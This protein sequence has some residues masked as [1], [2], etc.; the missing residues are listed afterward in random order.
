MKKL[1]SLILFVTL[2]LNLVAQDKFFSMADQFFNSVVADGKVNYKLIKNDPSSLEKLNSMV[3]DYKPEDGFTD[4]NKAFYINAYNLTVVTQIINHYPI[5]SPMDV[6]GFFDRN[7]FLI[8]GEE[9]TLNYLEK[10]LLSPNYKDPRFHF[11]LV[12]GATGCPPIT[13][14]AYMPDKL[15]A[16]MDKQTKLALNNPE[17]I[18]YREGEVSLSEIFKWYEADFIDQSSTIIDYINN[19]RN[20]PLPSGVKSGFY[21][22]DWSLNE[23]NKSINMSAT[24]SA[25]ETSNIF[26]YTPSK[27]L[28]KGQF[29]T[30]LFNNIY[31]QTAYR[32][33]DREKV[34]LETRDTY[35][36]GSFYI[37]Y[38]VSKNARVNI[39][40]D[41]NVKSVLIDTAKG[42]PF[43]VFKF[44]KTEYSRTALTSIGP[45]IK[46]QPFNKISNFSIQSAFWIP[47]A[48]DLE[49]IEEISDYPWMDYHMYTWWNQFFFDKSFGGKWQIFTEADL[50]FRFKSSKGS[51]PTHLD[52]PVSFFLSWFPT[53]KA[54]IYGQIQYSPRF[55]LETSTAYDWDLM[56]DYTINPF[57][58]ISDYAQ[59]GLGGKYQITNNFNV[60]VS[61][62]YFFTSRNGGA[63]YTM[64]LGL[65]YIL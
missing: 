51:I 17:F 19:Y 34:D 49:S 63:G 62:T 35:Y 6:P 50:L 25:V 56:Q 23:T 4:R 61:G 47:I 39:G 42:N 38:G 16:Q 55:Q 8:A 7:E 58:V 53:S 24:A 12:C 31:T 36:S 40:F 46:F 18:K 41:L 32:N 1:S 20:M 57:E 5:S 15:D 9:M 30:Q 65:R 33:E 37:L 28:K 10:D 26:S 54:T 60:E 45:K 43:E 64:N 48:K 11:V 21:T 27:L 29:E 22:Y 14:F 13:P 44:T 59:T 2:G 52:V 3:R